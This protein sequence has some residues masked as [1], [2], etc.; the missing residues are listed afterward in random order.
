MA[1]YIYFSIKTKRNKYK[2]TQSDTRREIGK[3]FLTQVLVIR[4]SK[5][6]VTEKPHINADIIRN[7]DRKAHK[8]SLLYTGLLLS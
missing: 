3:Q 7:L 1:W 4:L 8:H 2:D 6:Q 5:K